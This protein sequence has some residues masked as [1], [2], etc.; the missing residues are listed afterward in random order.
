MVDWNSKIFYERFIGFL[1]ANIILAFTF[2]GIYR[3]I[4]EFNGDFEDMK[5]PMDY[6]YFS[7]IT[8]STIGYG[9]HSPKTNLGKVA[10]CAQSFIFWM[11]ALTF[12]ILGDEE[13]IG[14]ILNPNPKYWNVPY[15]QYKKIV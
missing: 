8:Q 11:I 5:D 3:G 4:Q 2:A 9:D 14:Y 6:F 13:N 15:S 12:A 1:V 7:W 10:V